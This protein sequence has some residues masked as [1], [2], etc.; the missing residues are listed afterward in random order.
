MAIGCGLLL[1]AGG[2]SIVKD[3]RCWVQVAGFWAVDAG[4]RLV[5]GVLL[6]RVCGCCLQPG[7]CKL[8]HVFCIHYF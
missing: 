4:H 5:V 8:S 7:G 2:L 3:C 6:L 1:F